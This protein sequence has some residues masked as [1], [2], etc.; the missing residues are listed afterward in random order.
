MLNHGQ[1]EEPQ[2]PQ[3]IKDIMSFKRYLIQ[4]HPTPFISRILEPIA[5]ISMRVACCRSLKD[6]SAGLIAFALRESLLRV[7]IL[8]D[9]GLRNP[10]PHKIY[11]QLD[12]SS[13]K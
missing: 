10:I 7:A 2:P 13:N 6:P 5:G 1:A 3:K 4:I 9:A 8:I 11:K 12:Y